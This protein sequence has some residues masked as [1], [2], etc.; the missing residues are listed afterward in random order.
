MAVDLA[1]IDMF[2]RPGHIKAELVLLTSHVTCQVTFS[3]T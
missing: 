2:K 3:R 1:Q